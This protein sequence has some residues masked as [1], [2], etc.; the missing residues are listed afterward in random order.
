MLNARLQEPAPGKIQLLTGPRQVGKTTLLL[1]LVRMDPRH[2]MY[3]ALDA[4][5]A[6]LSGFWEQLWTRVE[7]MA[8]Q[9]HVALFLDEI[10][11]LPDWSGRLKHQWDLLQRE[12]WPVHVVASGSSALH[13]GQGARESLAGR[14]EKLQ[15]SHWS[16]MDFVENLHVLKEEAAYAVVQTGGYPGAFPLRRDLPRWA[17]FVRESMVEPAIGRD[18]LSLQAIKKPGLFRQLFSVCAT[19]PA[20]IVSLQKLQGQLQERGALETL[21]HYL[22]LLAE[23]ELAVGLEKYASETL[24]RRNAPPKIILLNNALAAVMDPRGIPDKKLDPERFG[25]WVENACLAHAWNQ[26]QRVTYWREE[27]HE[28]DGVLEGSWGSWAIEVKTGAFGAHDMRG[29]L[30]FKQAHPAFQLLVV[31]S[32]QMEPLAERMGIQ[33]MSWVDFLLAEGIEGASLMKNGT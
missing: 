33:A 28:V 13:L 32:P 8:R 31:C 25:H 29:L 15:L 23:A 16:A 11:C 12:R 10:Q 7:S 24:R 18:L 17:S 14:V 4:P 1:S 26:G 2:A 19:I 21:S 3:V 27:N 22:H 30:A 20:Y 6:A 9:G 5:E